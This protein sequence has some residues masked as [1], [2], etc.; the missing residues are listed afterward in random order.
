MSDAFNGWT[1]LKA[2]P[3]AV[4]EGGACRRISSNRNPPSSLRLPFP[5][6]VEIPEPPLPPDMLVLDVFPFS[7]RPD[8]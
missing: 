8:Y 1:S 5:N 2:L 6:R 7:Y 3:C 4:P